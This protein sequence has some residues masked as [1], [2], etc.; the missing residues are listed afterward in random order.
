METNKSTNNASN[1]LNN[2]IGGR[3]TREQKR[4]YKKLKY[5]VCFLELIKF[6]MTNRLIIAF[7]SPESNSMLTQHRSLIELF[8]ISNQTQLFQQI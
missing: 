5:E 6:S 8:K 1:L 3:V 2:L 7:S 4:K